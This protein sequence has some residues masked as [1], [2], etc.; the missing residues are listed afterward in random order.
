MCADLVGV[1]SVDFG[2]WRMPLETS[3]L[4]AEDDQAAVAAANRWI[5]LRAGHLASLVTAPS[6]R[7]ELTLAVLDSAAD[8]PVPLAFVRGSLRAAAGDLDGALADLARVACER[9][10]DQD[11]RRSHALVLALAGRRDQA[12]SQLHDFAASLAAV[13]GTELL[14]ASVTA[15]AEELGRRPD[16]AWAW[17]GAADGPLVADL[18]R[19]RAAGTLDAPRL[20]IVVADQASLNVA[21]E[22]GL[23]ALAADGIDPETLPD[24]EI[25]VEDD[26]P[27][28]RWRRLAVAALVVADPDGYDHR[29]ARRLGVPA[30]DVAA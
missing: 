10:F 21:A 9:P 2:E 7:P 24:T 14:R 13:P 1:P 25:V 19:A 8:V 17:I 4:E 23:A 29:L 11:A 28:Q 15:E 22:A 26:R 27:L 20:R 30:R 12:A 5:R 3:V 18:L 16:T 6:P